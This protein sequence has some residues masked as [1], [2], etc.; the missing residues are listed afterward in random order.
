MDNDY[1]LS[2]SRS[3]QVNWMPGIDRFGWR[4]API[5]RRLSV[6]IHVKKCG[7]RTLKASNLQSNM[8]STRPQQD[9]MTDMF[10][11]MLTTS[12]FNG[13]RTAS[14]GDSVKMIATSYLMRAC[15]GII[16]TVGESIKKMVVASSKRFK[17]SSSVAEPDAPK[18]NILHVSERTAVSAMVHLLET[19]RALRVVGRLGKSSD[20]FDLS[21]VDSRNLLLAGD[22][23]VV[24]Q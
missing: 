20:E 8:A 13:N 5:S 12:L 22:D 7:F 3:C 2:L 23:Q 19:Q 14:L 17:S 15:P 9:S 1:E 11:M 10:S 16:S 6:F 24:L 21:Q 4:F 18:K